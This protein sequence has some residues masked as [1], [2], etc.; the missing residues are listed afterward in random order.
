MVLLLLSKKRLS[1]E[2]CLAIFHP[3]TSVRLGKSYVRNV[4][5]AAN[6]EIGR[7]VLCDMMFISEIMIRI[8]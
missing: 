8:F 4:S 7:N 1:P 2:S 5:L 6:D 3:K